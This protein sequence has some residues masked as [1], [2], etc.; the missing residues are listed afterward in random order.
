MLGA[1][2]AIVG[3]VVTGGLAAA[4]AFGKALTPVAAVV[5]GAF[6]IAIVVFA[7]F[8]FL[9]VMVSFVM[10]SSFA[11][12][13]RFAEK[14]ERHVQEGS[15]GE[16]GVSNVLAHIVL[17]TAIAVASGLAWISTPAAAALFAGAFAFGLSD[18]LASEF[19]VLSGRAVSIL[20]LRPVPAGTNGGV[21]SVGELFALA[22][23][24]SIGLFGALA[25]FL[26]HTPIGPVVGFVAT[27]TIAGF[28][29][30]Q[31]DSVLGETLENRG[32]LS[33]GGT[34]FLGMLA[35]IGV[36]AGLF[37]LIG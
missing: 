5:A 13:Y 4:A 32:L 31:I 19:G 27:V 1:V 29:A 2:L 23:A 28:V 16:R 12:R 20:T 26:T 10:V 36:A 30:C 21:S 34:N 14:A 22:G 6:G 7:G 37:V 15:R 33:K 3:A 35:A 9:G 17:P 18:T 11:T 24:A 8:G 25:F